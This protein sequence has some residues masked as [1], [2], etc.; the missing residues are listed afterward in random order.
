MANTV[1][2]KAELATV[3]N[4]PAMIQPTQELVARAYDAIH[5][6]NVPPEVGDPAITARA[7]QERIKSGTLEQSMQAAESL[8]SLGEKYEG[9]KIAVCAFHLLPSSFEIQEGSNKGKKGVYAVV[10]VMTQDGE[11]DTVQTGAGNIL[12]QLVKA[13]EESLDGRSRFPFTCVVEVKPTGTP[14]RSTQ[15]LRAPAAA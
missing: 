2:Q 14:G 1:E 7:I 4:A 11:L 9:Q 10:E 3:G 6:A 12:T 5:N 8:P 15:W 13:W